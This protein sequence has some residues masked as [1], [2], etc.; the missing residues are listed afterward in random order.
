MINRV[1][2]PLGMICARIALVWALCAPQ[3][4]RTATAP[5][6]AAD[7][8]VEKSV[9]LPDAPREKLGRGRI[10]GRGVS[11]VESDIELPFSIALKMRNLQG[12][13]DRVAR[14]E[15]VGETEMT[16]KY[17]PNRNVHAEISKWL[18]EQGFEITLVD[19]THTTIF[20]RGK[21][22]TIARVFRVE[23]GRVSTPQGEFTSALS[24]PKL[25]RRFSGAVLAINGLQPQ[26]RPQRANLSRSLYTPA[27]P[28]YPAGTLPNGNYGITPKELAAAYRLPATLN[29]AGQTIALIE[30]SGINPTDLNTFW[31]GMGVAQTTANLTVIGNPAI[32]TDKSLFGEATMDVE[33]A[34]ALAPAAKL[35]M[36]VVSQSFDATNTEILN[37]VLVNKLPITVLS[38]SFCTLENDLSAGAVATSSQI[39]AQLAAAGVSVFAS[40]GDTGTNSNN[41]GGGGAYNPSYP[42]IV[43]YPA[44]DPSVTGVGGTSLPLSSDFSN[45]SEVVWSGIATGGPHATGGGIS[46]LFPRPAWQTGGTT[47]AVQTMRCV[48]DVAALADYGA[49][50]QAGYWGAVGGTSLSAPIWGGIAALLNQ[51]RANLG[52]GPLGLLN[53]YIYSGSVAGAFKDITSGTNG[54]YRA[55]AGYDLCTGLG[56]PNVT[57]LVSALASPS[58][59]RISTQPINQAVTIGRPATFTVA[60]TQS[61]GTLSYQWYFNGSPLTGG[62]TASY[63]VANAVF[64]D[65]GAYAVT[66]TGQQGAI[67]SFPAQLDI[68]YI[69]AITAQPK[70][71]TLEVGQNLVFSVDVTGNPLPTYQWQKSTDSG[72]TWANLTDSG[73]RTGSSTAK[74]IMGPATAD[75]SGNR[76]RAIITNV[77]GSVT[78]STAQATVVSETTAPASYMVSTLAGI[79]TRG[80]EDGPGLA[81]RFNKPYGIAVAASGNV[82]VSDERNSSVRKITPE[83]V[84]STLAGGSDGPF[85]YTRGIAVDGAENVYVIS[86]NT[87][88]IHKITP[89]G[90]IT[91]VAG[92]TIDTGDG[93]GKPLAMYVPRHMAIDPLGN[94]YIADSQNYIIL[95]INPSGKVTTLAGKKGASEYVD[96]SAAEARLSY[97]SGIALDGAGNVWVADRGAQAIR[98]I[99]PEGAVSTLAGGGPLY[100]YRDGQGKN[101]TF[102]NP[103]GLAIDQAGN[104][105][106]N[107]NS[108]EVIR[109]VSPSGEVT[110]LAGAIASYKNKLIYCP[111]DPTTE[112]GAPGHKGCADGQGYNALFNDPQGIGVARDGTLY[113]ADTGNNL[114]RK[115]SAGGVVTTLA[116]SPPAAINGPG[117]TARMGIAFG[118]AMD[119]SGNTY[120]TDSYNYVIRKVSSTGVVSI[121][122]GKAGVPGSDD[123]IGINA[124][125]DRP[126]GIAVDSAGNVYVSDYNNFTIRKITPDGLVSTLAGKA[127]TFGSQN[128]TGEEAR[129]SNLAGVAVDKAGNVYVADRGNCQVRKITPL[130]VVSSLAGTW[131]LA[132]FKEGAGEQALFAIDDSSQLAVDDTG[133]VFLADTYNSRIRRITPS[134]V[135]STFAG[136]GRFNYS[137][138]D[139]V[140]EAASFRMPVGITIDRTGN[141]FVT[142]LIGCSVRKITPEAKVTTIAGYSYGGYRDGLGATAEFFS[143]AAIAVDGTG[144]LVLADTENSA[145]RVIRPTTLP[146]IAPAFAALPTAQVVAAGGSIT[147]S[148]AATGETPT[149]QWFKNSVAINGATKAS[150]TITGAGK[151]DDAS[152]S[153]SATN[154]SGSV[155]STAVRLAVVSS[156]T[157]TSTPGNVAIVANDRAQLKVSATGNGSLV[158]QWYQ[159]ATGVT[160]TPISGANAALFTTP[161]L[162][163][164]TNYWVRVTDAGGI[165]VDSAAATVAVSATSPLAVTHAVMGPGYSGGGA[166]TVTNTLT[167]TGTAP[168]SISWST[169]LPT[170]WKY[171]GSGGS[172]GVT[173]PTFERGDLLEW[174]WTTVPASPITFTY[175]LSVPAGT[176]ADQVIVALV[177]SQAA[178]AQS[179]TMAKPDPLVVRPSA[180]LHSADSDRD[181]RIGLVEL[182][183]VI[184]LYNYRAGTNRTGQYKSSASTEDGFAPGP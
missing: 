165:A 127:R 170:G 183:R 48:P 100:G 40:S 152:Y 106:V 5:E 111:I 112:V 75:L 145:L 85:S 23:F 32:S 121:V 73:Q 3:L 117:L 26:I 95:K 18:E 120:F 101:A 161:T 142:D 11:A 140:G 31:A 86:S 17:R 169:L 50:H 115:I 61:T 4:G 148:A 157:L 177:A 138:L 47:L 90:V 13:R 91:T 134:G 39:Y 129:F 88:T 174:S 77:S 64:S 57:N 29:G 2:P 87:S 68:Q 114:I 162:S 1:R 21:I 168:S 65:V 8:S 60:A 130:G 146:A 150:L 89:Q 176:T 38:I 70:N 167:Y 59:V 79:P 12:L 180:A 20:A 179:Q 109:K 43:S 96:G 175:T 42:L 139:G 141:L 93:T 76:F 126:Q 155:T 158:Y 71:V 107:D 172:E 119:A 69:S 67:T 149:Y 22:S 36:Y 49:V 58:G 28:H 35:R 103:E 25:P 80:R 116:G 131:R 110:T 55:V 6:S 108:S 27:A 9:V 54:A 82:Y 30:C 56:T 52:L 34:G 41:P 124:R 16:A 181:G 63:T 171:I 46:A 182:T 33:W 113:V 84:V 128:G 14:K 72:A 143:P 132:G 78:S 135:V 104:L 7:T 15:R 163:E 133:N 123:G 164:S 62:T 144:R 153:V 178:G 44:S 125:F 37:D 160:T 156:V 151:V 53:S 137:T 173:R 45:P 92:G 159:G 154:S 83:G 97:P 122:A 102:F 74:L 81:A 24:E 118:V 136:D 10:L 184:E 105:Y 19:A 98:K 147:L 94:L 99:T 51:A 166:V 66:V